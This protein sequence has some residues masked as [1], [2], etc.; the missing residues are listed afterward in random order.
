MPDTISLALWGGIIC[1]AMVGKVLGREVGGAGLLRFVCVRYQNSEE[2][3][4]FV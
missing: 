1:E 3:L 2:V 4:T